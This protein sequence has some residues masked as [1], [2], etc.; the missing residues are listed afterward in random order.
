MAQVTVALR[1]RVPFRLKL[2]MRLLAVW[3]WLG[4]FFPDGLVSVEVDPQ[5]LAN[6]VQIKVG[7]RRWKRLDE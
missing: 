5:K 1:V 4:S 6:G 2:T 7:G 3:V